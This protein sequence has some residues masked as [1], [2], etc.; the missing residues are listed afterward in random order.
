MAKILTHPEHG[1]RDTRA[2]DQLRAP[3]PTSRMKFWLIAGAVLLALF[4]LQPVWRWLASGGQAV[5]ASEMRFATVQRSD[6][7]ADVSGYAQ[8]VAARA[9][10]LPAPRVPFAL[11]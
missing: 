8:V 4:L 1:F 3:A 6:F 11:R 5:R 10:S 7:V 9:P 2:Q